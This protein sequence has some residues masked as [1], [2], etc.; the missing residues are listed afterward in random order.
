MLTTTQN[1][2]PVVWEH[3][4]VLHLCEGSRLVPRDRE[5][6]VLWT[7]CGW[8]DVPANAAWEKLPTERV[9]CVACLD[10]AAQEATDVN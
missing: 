8:Y 6:F 3:R 1:N 2:R 4:G 7:R 9:T 5:T 10:R